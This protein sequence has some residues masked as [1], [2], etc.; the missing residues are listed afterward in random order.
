[1]SRESAPP[2]RIKEKHRN[3]LLANHPDTGGSTYI[4]GK[5][6]E[7]KEMLLNEKSSAGTSF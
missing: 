4:A 6:N 7:A 2:Q 5:I 1:M 3:L